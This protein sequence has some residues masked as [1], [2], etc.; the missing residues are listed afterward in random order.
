MSAVAIQLSG[1][2]LATFNPVAKLAAAAAVL[3]GLLVTADLV[4]ASIVLGA[5]LVAIPFAGIRTRALAARAWPLPVAAAGVALANLVASSAGPA[6]ITAVSLRLLA[7]ALPGILVFA[8]TEPVDLAD[9]LVQ[10]LRV[11]PRFAYGSLA[12]LGL[13]PLLTVDWATIRRA[14]RARGIDAGRSP[15]AAIRLF[16][17]AVFALLVT[18]IR[19]ATRLGAAMDSRGFDHHR[20]RTAAR[21]QRFGAA[22]AAL[23]A[24]TVA[25]VA[26]AN[27]AALLAGTWHPLLG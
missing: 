23:V 8:T 22:D 1:S 27:A 2:R 5:E 16:S 3:V 11:A 26:A 17:S 7:I 9:S 20:P 12:A 24:V 21:R 4:A 6:T 18:A 10:Q 19:R 14:R 15:L 25:V 13:L